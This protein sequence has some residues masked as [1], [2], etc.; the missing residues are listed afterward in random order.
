MAT[1]EGQMVHLARELHKVKQAMLERRVCEESHRHLVAGVGDIVA[2]TP[3]EKMAP[4]Q[5][6]ATI[7]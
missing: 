1:M 6:D 5:P 4:S 7:A 2:T 3:G